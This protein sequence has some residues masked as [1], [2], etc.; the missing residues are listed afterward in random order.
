M[1][2]SVFYKPPD[3]KNRREICKQGAQAMGPSSY[4]IIRKLPC[5]ERHKH[6]GKSKVVYHYWKIVPKST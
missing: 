2:N 6:D 4:P 3:K 1:I 5:P